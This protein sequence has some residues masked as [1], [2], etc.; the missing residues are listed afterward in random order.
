MLASSS[1]EAKQL[2]GL[3]APSDSNKVSGSEKMFTLASCSKV[4]AAFLSSVTTSFIF[5]Y[6]SVSSVSKRSKYSSLGNL[7]RLQIL[8]LFGNQLSGTVPSSLSNL[9][10]LTTL[11]LDNNQLSSISIPDNWQPPGICQLYY[12]KFLCPIPQWASVWC[13][14]VCT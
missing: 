10:Q 11:Y 2:S 9:T 5:S 7:A 12:N 13:A 8:N 6:L 3:F 14:A 4:A 1:H